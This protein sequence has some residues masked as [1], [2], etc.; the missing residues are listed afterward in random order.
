MT[1]VAL[2]PACIAVQLAVAILASAFGPRCTR[3]DDDASAQAGGDAVDCAGIAHRIAAIAAELEHTRERMVADRAHA[4][5]QRRR[6]NAAIALSLA[7]A[8]AASSFWDG[9]GGAAILACG[10]LAAIAAGLTHRALRSAKAR[11]AE[12]R[13]RIARLEALDQS[14][15]ADFAARRSVLAPFQPVPPALPA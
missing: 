14:N 5:R 6:R 7:A 12:A 2:L 4:V 15:R 13:A 8:I 11:V 10:V 3:R 1:A 9:P